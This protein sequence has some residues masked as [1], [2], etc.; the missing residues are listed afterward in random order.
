[1]ER[2][3]LLSA[4]PIHGVGK[5]GAGG[6]SVGSGRP[7]QGSPS[8]GVKEANARSGSVGASRSVHGVGEADARGESVGAGRPVHGVP[9]HGVKEANARDEHIAVCRPVHG[10]GEADAGGESA[11]AYNPSTE[12]VSFRLLHT[13][14]AHLDSYT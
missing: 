9:V 5:A 13:P 4:F 1:M 10:V 7:V 11:G 6:E 14:V 3:L 2:V 8:T 12:G